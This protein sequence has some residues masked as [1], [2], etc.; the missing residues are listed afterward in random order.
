[1]VL[2]ALFEVVQCWSIVI[3]LLLVLWSS[4]YS[5]IWF[6]C[7]IC[8][9]FLCFYDTTPWWD[10]DKKCSSI[11]YLCPSILWCLYSR[12]WM[13]RYRVC[14]QEASVFMLYFLKQEMWPVFFVHMTKDQSQI[15]ILL[16]TQAICWSS[17]WLS[18]SIVAYQLLFSLL[19]IAFEFVFSLFLSCNGG[20]QG[21]TNSKTA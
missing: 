19:R 12:T 21:Q 8:S 10:L 15:Q 17:Q 11:A 4:T 1:M 14:Q 18:R 2:W 5:L 6:L 16:S 13:C 7:D 20:W 3:W 9:R